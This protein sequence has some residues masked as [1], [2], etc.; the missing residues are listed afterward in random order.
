MKPNRWIGLVAHAV[1][2]GVVTYGLWTN[3]DPAAR[4]VLALTAWLD[5]WTVGTYFERYGW[6]WEPWRPPSITD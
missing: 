4:V 2:L 3:D 1:A 5:G 6:P